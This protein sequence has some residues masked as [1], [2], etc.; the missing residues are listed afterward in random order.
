MDERRLTIIIVPDGDPETRTYRIPYGKVKLVAT[1]AVTA[2]VVFIIMA[3]SW[4]YVAAQ[5]AR[6][7]NLERQVTQLEAQRAKVAQLAKTL[8][9]V[10]AQ[11]ERVRHMLG[12]DASDGTTDP[13]LPPVGPAG[14]DSARPQALAPGQR[15]PAGN[16]ATGNPSAGSPPTSWPLAQAGY[17]TQ[18]L[19]ETG[20]GE[21]PGIDIAVPRDSYIRAAGA[22][23][24]IQAGRDDVY[25]DY[26]LIDHGDGYRSLYGHASRL[27]VKP[28]EHVERD[29]VI[30]LSGS[31]GHSTAPHLHFEIRRNGRPVDPLTL[32]KRP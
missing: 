15:A 21:H 29:Q 16:A 26:V 22:G 13:S 32:V 24:V 20:T 4:W 5:A 1:V 18:P 12:A 2:V 8:S 27:F 14:R 31:T 11:Y 9:Q 25:G 10:E 19:A 17:I 30:A 23:T 28:G 3:A 6:V 7:P